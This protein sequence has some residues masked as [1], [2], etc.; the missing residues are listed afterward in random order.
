MK[1]TK[2][3]TFNQKLLRF[4]KFQ[5]SFRRSTGDDED[6]ARGYMPI[7]CFSTTPLFLSDFRGEICLKSPSAKCRQKRISDHRIYWFSLNSERVFN[8]SNPATPTI[9]TKSGNTRCSL[10]FFFV[11]YGFVRS[12]KF[13][14]IEK[15]TVHPITF[16]AANRRQKRRR[17]GMCRR[18]LVR[19]ESKLMV[20]VFN[21]AI[22]N[23]LLS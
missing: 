5:R 12:R 20:Y 14:R 13:V 16:T 7:A 22:K 4:F 21:N 10:A 8:C 1:L 17:R 2:T 15:V 6:F 9:K 23:N 19:F 3:F 18:Q 11:L